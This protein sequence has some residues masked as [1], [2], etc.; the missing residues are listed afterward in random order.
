M[1]YTFRSPKGIHQQP[2]DERSD[3]LG[4]D[5]PF[6]TLERFHFAAFPHATHC[7]VVLRGLL[8]RESPMAHPWATAGSPLGVIHPRW[9]WISIRDHL[10]PMGLNCW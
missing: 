9:F 3:S 6:I 2:R 7:G 8:P 5:H 10:W 1:D 4:K